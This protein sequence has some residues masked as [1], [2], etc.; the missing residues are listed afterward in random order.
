MTSSNQDKH[1]F[2][3]E[4]S[5]LSSSPYFTTQTSNKH[6]DL[7]LPPPPLTT[8][9]YP[10]H[11]PPYPLPPHPMCYA[12]PGYPTGPNAYPQGYA[13]YANGYPANHYAHK[14]PYY[15]PP[16]TYHSSDTSNHFYRRFLL[17]SCF[18]VTCLL[19][20]SLMLTLVLLPEIP[21]YKVA[22][23]SVTN[24]T[25]TPTLARQ[26]DT[27]MIVENPNEK[28]VAYFSEFK[29]GFLYKDGLLAG[30]YVPSFVL[31]DKVDLDVKGSSRKFN[32]ELIEKTTMD[33]LVKEQGT[34]SITFTLRVSS[35][36]MFKSGSFSTRTAEIVAICEGLKVVFQNNNATGALDNGGK[37]IECET[38]V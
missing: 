3:S 8:T 15:G 31:K 23:L 4:P 19:F 22:S 24:F 21:K 6:V 28:L 2:Q 7:S 32:G 20:A 9:V 37:P 26:W 1:N 33:N 35:V 25:T 29:V 14:T 10:V 11:P 5:L 17:W 13:M 27:K 30:N 38:Y 36:N 12:P 34:G 16:P 18:L